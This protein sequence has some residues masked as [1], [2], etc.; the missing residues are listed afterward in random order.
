MYL[1][2]QNMFTMEKLS[3]HIYLNMFWSSIHLLQYFTHS[4]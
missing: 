3:M 4:K 1:K 2:V